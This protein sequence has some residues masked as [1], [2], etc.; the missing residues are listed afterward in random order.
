MGD[1]LGVLPFVNNMVLMR[2]KGSD[3]MEAL[4]WS[5]TDYN[6]EE[7]KGKFLQMSGTYL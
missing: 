6:R 4:E 1:I 2:M 5:V 7:R 3:I